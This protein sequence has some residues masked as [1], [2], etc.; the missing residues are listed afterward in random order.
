[1]ESRNSMRADILKLGELV[2]NYINDKN[3]S[4]A[5]AELS[6]MTDLKGDDI[7]E[8]LD[9]IKLDILDIN[10]REEYKQLR[11]DHVDLKSNYEEKIKDYTELKEN[12]KKLL[13]ALELVREDPFINFIGKANDLIKI[14]EEAR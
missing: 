6:N 13:D 11:D 9:N 1:M 2:K 3:N 10:K 14:I 4:T 8:A 5:K 12:Y 7:I